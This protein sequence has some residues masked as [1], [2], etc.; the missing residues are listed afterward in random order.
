V[1]V[2]E[3]AGRQSEGMLAR[4]LAAGACAG[5]LN[6]TLCYAGIPVS[7]S[8]FDWHL[9]PA[10]A[11]HGAILAAGAYLS[12]RGSQ[13]ISSTHVM[14]RALLAG[15]LAGY[16]SWQP[17]RMSLE[18]TAGLVLWPFDSSWIAVAFGPLQYFGLVVL[19]SAL[20]P[21]RWTVMC[22]RKT[23]TLLAFIAAGALGSLWW[24]IEIGPWYYS[25]IHGSFWGL[26]TASA[27][28]TS[29]SRS[30]AVAARAPARSP[31]TQAVMPGPRHA[32][33]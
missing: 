5:A 3:T 4:W 9:I 17:S 18:G 16:F 10:G 1:R 19:I 24:W 2:Q 14:S 27:A 15:W 29:A 22:A 21:T 28:Y 13:T 30:K 20:M 25:V 12:R 32:T 31:R 33:P 23:T 6:A 8:D 26:A 7:V 11:V